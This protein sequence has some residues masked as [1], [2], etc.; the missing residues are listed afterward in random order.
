[1]QLALRTG[2]GVFLLVGLCSCRLC[3][4]WCSLVGGQ[5][6]VIWRSWVLLPSHRC[7]FVLVLMLL[8]RLLAN[9]SWNHAVTNTGGVF[10][11]SHSFAKSQNKDW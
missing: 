7:E 6:R 1:M 4:S 8:L 9:G 3:S 10:E 11:R 2:D 5:D